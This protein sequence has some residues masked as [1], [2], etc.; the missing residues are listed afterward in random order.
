MQRH[1]QPY[2][3]GL[4]MQIMKRILVALDASPRAPAVL[5]AALSLASSTGAKVRLFRAI[6]VQPEIPW[7][8]I[9]EFPPGGLEELLAQYA[10][11][12]LGARARDVPAELLDGVATGIGSAW[13]AI[14]AAGREYDADLIVIG[15]HGYGAV[16]HVLGT[17][18]GK[19]V[20]H[21]E[22]SVLVVRDRG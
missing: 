18:A 17:T 2:R 9:R 14:C 6:P 16:D 5:A 15:S 21:A 3:W 20:N 8:M 19:V 13:S 1:F 12:D 4:I 11:A 22:R 10:K 7:D